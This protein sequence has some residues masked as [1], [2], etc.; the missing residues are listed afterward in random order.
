MATGSGATIR[1]GVAGYSTRS[2]TTGSKKGL[3]ARCGR[4]SSAG[5]P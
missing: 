2:V 5:R 1:A 4:C 3:T